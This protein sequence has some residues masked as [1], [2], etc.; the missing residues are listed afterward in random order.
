LAA[1]SARASPQERPAPLFLTFDPMTA[2]EYLYAAM[3]VV[4]VWLVPE[5]LGRGAFRLLTA[6]AN[7]SK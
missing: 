1:R 5:V 4:I 2:S 3:T 7:V 6:A